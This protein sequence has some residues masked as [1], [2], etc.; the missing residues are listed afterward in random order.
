VNGTR[1]VDGKAGTVVD[2]R[3]T[4]PGP[5]LIVCPPMTVVSGVDPEPIGYVVPLITAS[6]ASTDMTRPPMVVT[7]NEGVASEPSGPTVVLGKTTPAGPMVST[8]PLIWVVIG[9]APGPIVKVWPPIITSCWPNVNT[10]PP[11]VMVD[12]AAGLPAVAGV[13]T[14]ATGTAMV[15][16]GAMT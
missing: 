2:A 15:V 1:A 13:V 4:P 14:A 9:T 7:E 12:M 5:I 8:W 16:P 11:T 6:V 10:T 3:P